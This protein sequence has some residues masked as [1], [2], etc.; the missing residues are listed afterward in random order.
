MPDDHQCKMA[1]WGGGVAGEEG[2]LSPCLVH[3]KDPDNNS[4]QSGKLSF[5]SSLLTED[6]TVKY[7]FEASDCHGFISGNIVFVYL[8]LHR[9]QKL[10]KQ[11]QFVFP[12][13]D[14]YAPYLD[15]RFALSV[16]DFA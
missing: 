3:F 1:G 6:I 16:L 4:A 11:K 14:S 2:C 12:A 5:P 8:G 9:L 10:M 13:S 15:V 7:N